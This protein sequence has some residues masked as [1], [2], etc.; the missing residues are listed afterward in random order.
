MHTKIIKNVVLTVAGLALSHCV[1]L[2]QP[3]VPNAATSM[4]FPF[5]D[6]ST[7]VADY[8]TP[9][10]PTFGVS[11]NLSNY[12]RFRLLTNYHGIYGSG[13]S[14]LHV[15]LNLSTNAE[16]A[17]PGGEGSS[18][19]T[20]P[21]L[22]VTNS[23]LDLGVI[24]SFTASIW[25]NPKNTA[26][27]ATTEI[28]LFILGA[29]GD[30]ANANNLSMFW[31]TVNQLDGTVGSTTVNGAAPTFPTT[32]DTGVFPT[33]QWL[34]QCLTWDGT[35]AT[36]YTGTDGGGP[37]TVSGTATTSTTISL[38]GANDEL[39]VGNREDTAARPFCGLLDDLRFYGSTAPVTGAANANQV[40]DIFW[41]GQAPTNLSGTGGNNAVNLTWSPLA[42]A[43]TYIISRS[44]TSG[45]PYTQL[46]AGLTTTSYQDTT[47]VN[48]N[49]YYYVVSAVD[50]TGDL[51]TGGQSYQLSILAEPP[52]TQ[53][54]LTPTAGSDQVVLNWT[55][56]T[57]TPGPITYNVARATNSGA[58]V[59]IASGLSA[60]TYTDTNVVSQIKYYYVITA[61]NDGLATASTASAEVSVTPA[62]P[63]PA[64][65]TVYAA[66]SGSGQAIVSW[67]DMG[68]TSYTV[69][70]ATSVGGPYT[71]IATGLTGTTYTDATIT[72]TV[73]YYYYEVVAVNALSLS[74]APSSPSDA[75]PGG[76]GN[77]LVNPGFEL[78]PSATGWTRITG[79]GGASAGSINVITASPTTT[80][81]NSTTG[82][83]P[84][85]PAALLVTTHNGTNVGNIYN[86]S[87]SG[88]INSWS[89]QVG[90][91]P[92]SAW[93]ASAWTLAGHEDLSGPNV[94]WYEVDF[95]NAGGTILASY[96][97][98]GISNLVCAGLNPI[99]LDT[100]VS[101]AVTNQMQVTAGTNTGVIIGNTGLSG[102]MTAPPGTVT[103]NFQ[104][105]FQDIGGHGG[106]MYLDDCDLDLIAGP[107]PPTI[108]AVTNTIN[109]AVLVT[110]TSLTVTAKSSTGTITNAQA[111]LTTHGLTGATNTVTNNLNST[112]FGLGTATAI[113][114]NPLSPNLVYK[115]TILATDNN[116]NSATTSATF[117]T[118]APVL[119]IEASDFN[120]SGGSFYDTPANGGLALFATAPL[121]VSETDYQKA[122]NGS[123]AADGSY[124]RKT[125]AIIC[126]PAAPNAGGTGTE[127]KFLI[128][129]ANGDTT[130]IEVEVGYN[131][132]GNWLDFTRTY[133]SG[134]PGVG[135]SAPAGTYNIWVYEATDGSGAQDSMSLV[136]PSPVTSSTQTNTAIGTFSLTDGGWNTFE[137]VPCVD[138][139]G[140]LVSV[141]LSGVATLRDT[142]VGNP[143]I[144]FYMLTPVTP[145]LTPGLQYSYPDGLHPFEPTNHFTFT[146][147]PNNGAAIASSGISLVLNGVNV[148]PELTLT[149]SGTS[150]VGSY[151]I[152]S[153]AV[154]SGTLS[155]TNTAA[156]APLYTV[157][158]LGFDTFS[159][160]NYQ[161]EAN[162]YD[163]STN[164]GTVWISGLFIDNPIPTC[165]VVNYAAGDYFATNSYFGYPT[166]FTPGKDPQGKGAV[167]QQGIDINFANDGEGAANEIYRA[168]GVGAVLAPDYVR[169]KFLAE[170]AVYSDPNIIPINIGYYNGGDWMNYTRHY[171]TNT[172][173]IWGRLAGGAG[174][175]SG[176]TLSMVTS[177]VGTANQTVTVLGSFTDPNPIGWETFQWIPLLNANGTPVIVSLGG[178]AT[179]RV[180]SGGNIDPEFYML[181][182]TTTPIQLTAA[183]AGNQIK[184]A[185]PTLIG[186]SYTLLSTTNLNT[187][188]WTQVGSAIVGNGA[189]QTVSEPATGQQAYYQVSVQ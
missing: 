150:W 15:G 67:T 135:V 41:A 154:Y 85:D 171:P 70:R 7:N 111:I 76:T 57:A 80:Y 51:T 28:R 179:L 160:S 120:F 181:T 25:C 88:S 81:D 9:S 74:S 55:A 66:P 93:A 64:P 136:T 6:L 187:Q 45:G 75:V 22:V 33:N 124:Y 5:T 104:A 186:H 96:E 121:G 29:T 102:A 19:G 152:A 116:G 130:D 131:S 44:T 108:T 97:S 172:Y 30:K 173:N 174:P 177:G 166:G 119:V 91:T 79:T 42:N 117:D 153:N 95:L 122:A 141:N 27:S 164:N 82:E 169:P 151:P 161:W 146:V 26:N 53:P 188:I 159:I 138:N 62:G 34:F 84:Q 165:D 148:T 14:G 86:Y 43:A 142:I 50:G 176:T 20:G 46:A 125:D 127:Q 59:I 155:I 11:L 184:I 40:E 54:V 90:A 21:Y 167:A 94:F 17:T 107:V 61:V 78:T 60:V 163:F 83:C 134:T 114:T 4:R 48:G 1:A 31:N 105:I 37:L 10:D 178:L 68:A 140:N 16:F 109:G 35:T 8:S 73:D 87:G 89:Q 18:E 113:I 3:L 126:G 99:P 170:Q 175:F 139:Y 72:L 52:P 12:N 92:G 189:V 13:T 98:F 106:S 143:N 38:T 156:P 162:D 39:Q 157:I 47:A 69:L 101:L 36:L 129:A 149:K 182:P 65:T 63:P 118:I 110:N 145:V 32:D 185:I 115:V 2:A 137:Y 112:T 100:W 24:N 158:N 133:G 77:Q 23:I 71:Q 132:V 144:G 123:Q 183:L 103:A 168:D 180:T 58:E 128:A 49:T 56:A 147:G